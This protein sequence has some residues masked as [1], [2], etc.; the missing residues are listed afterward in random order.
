M[1]ETVKDS[2]DEGVAGA[3]AGRG[4]AIIGLEGSGKTVF[5]AA[6]A[7]AMQERRE[8]PHLKASGADAIGTRRY[9]A[10]L[11]DTI[12]LGTWPAS[13]NAGT[14]RTLSWT[15]HSEKGETHTVWL[16]DCAGQDIREIFEKGG[17][18]AHQRRLAADIFA[19]GHVLV[20][21][22]LKELIDLHGVPGTTERRVN[23]ETAVCSAIQALS[24][25]GTPFSVLLTQYD[26]YKDA[27]EQHFGGDLLAAISHYSATLW[28]AVTECRAELL[29]VS[30]V[31]T[32]DRL[33][34]GAAGRFPAVNTAPHPS[35]MEV[36]HAVNARLLE[37]K[38][39][40]SSFWKWAATTCL[41]AVAAG[42][43]AYFLYVPD[44]GGERAVAAVAVPVPPQAP[45]PSSPDAGGTAT[46]ML[47]GNVP[48]ELVWCP[49]GSF[50]M[51]SPAGEA[52]RDGDETRHRVTLTK[53]FWLGKYEVTQGQWEAV[54]GAG[55]NPSGFKGAE[56]PVEQ[57][58][59]EDS[60]TFLKKVNALA[61]GG[62]FR[63]PTEAEWEYACRAGTET[64]FC[65][66]DSLDASMA[67]FDGGFPYGGG[68]KG[69]YREK[70]TRVGQFR[71]NGWGLYDMH[72][73]VWEWC[74]DWYGAY[75]VGAVTDPAGAA[76]GSY[77][78][79]RGGCWIHNASYCRSALRSI[80]APSNR[81]IYLGFRVA[82]TL[83]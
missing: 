52:E 57:V 13:T 40:R 62:G 75:P 42:V 34:G 33:K 23:A 16:P 73:N 6:L 30:A 26:A 27:V 44:S 64:A 60:Q 9:V 43:A 24:K 31:M 41:C 65:Y 22:N 67:N 53:G 74:Q 28:H 66:G 63:L 38:R 4:I 3:A 32:E 51:G 48:L 35:V 77:R 76:S 54:M 69:E 45:E 79:L 50:W 37:K 19:S 29:P 1:S 11:W 39:R 18:D 20:L 58:S 12:Q 14:L 55:T 56:L 15:W 17:G 49:A 71:P 61:S 25:A 2:A 82:R 21:F 8:C 72:G 80:V 46:V 78:V 5:L 36:A 7:Q 59:W 70:P 81:S 83:P 47:P 10:R 68:K